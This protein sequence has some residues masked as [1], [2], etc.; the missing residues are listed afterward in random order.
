MSF[1]LL[2][3]LLYKGI[4][5]SDGQRKPQNNSMRY[6]KFYHDNTLFDALA[7]LYSV[8]FVVVVDFD[9]GSHRRSSAMALTSH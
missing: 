1:L 4:V 5:Q 7:S 8:L 3:L 9:D 2:F 6:K